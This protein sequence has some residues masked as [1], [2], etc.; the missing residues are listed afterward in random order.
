MEAI[1]DL[2]LKMTTE[3]FAKMGTPGLLHVRTPTADNAT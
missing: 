2:Q 1:T 3:L